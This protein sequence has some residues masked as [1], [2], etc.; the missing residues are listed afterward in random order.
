MSDDDLSP[1]GTP[2]LPRTRVASASR[3]ESVDPLLDVD[4]LSDEPADVDQLSD[5]SDTQHG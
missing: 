5:A 3:A 1:F 4:L 2:K